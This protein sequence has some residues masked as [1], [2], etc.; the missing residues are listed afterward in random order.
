MS[1][2]S[3]GS[4]PAATTSPGYKQN[5]NCLRPVCYLIHFERPYQAKTGK[6]RQKA[7]HYLGWT[8]DLPKR[9]KL[10]ATGQ[11]ARL[12]A[13]V[14][15]EGIGWSVVRVWENG[16]FALEKKLKARHSHATYCPLC[17]QR[18]RGLLPKEPLGTA[19]VNAASEEAH[20]KGS[21]DVPALSPSSGQ[22]P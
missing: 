4:H 19:P 20:T 2:A 3:N 16:S 22:R 15:A 8:I 6:Q 14:N 10:H 9:V 1:H 12:L 17:N 21:D 7:Q 5:V 18:H 13:V 11:G